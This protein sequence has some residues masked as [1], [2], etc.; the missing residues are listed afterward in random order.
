VVAGQVG[1]A[2]P[3]PG[4][5]PSTWSAADLGLTDGRKLYIDVGYGTDSSVSGTGLW[6]DEIT[7]TNFQEIGPDQQSCPRP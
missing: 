4:W 5:L 7:L 3:G 6:I 2:G 1:W